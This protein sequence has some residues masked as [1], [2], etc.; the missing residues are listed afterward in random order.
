MRGRRAPMDSEKVSVAYVHDSMLVLA[1]QLRPLFPHHAKSMDDELTLWVLDA[2]GEWRG[3]PRNMTETRW[4]RLADIICS[5]ASLPGTYLDDETK[6]LRL[7]ALCAAEAPR[8]MA[9]HQ[10]GGKRGWG[11][12]DLAVHIA[13]AYSPPKAP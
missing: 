6:R 2:N 5:L 12:L 3:S 13:E 4:N 10:F 9:R 11:A 1:E 7:V 8:C